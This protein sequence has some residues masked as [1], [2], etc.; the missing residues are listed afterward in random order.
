MILLIVVEG[1]DGEVGA[2]VLGSRRDLFVLLQPLNVECA[3]VVGRIRRCFEQGQSSKQNRERKAGQAPQNQ[4][5]IG[6]E[7]RHSRVPALM[8]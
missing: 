4:V 2:S 7:G 3:C 8:T 6:Q 1:F 5:M